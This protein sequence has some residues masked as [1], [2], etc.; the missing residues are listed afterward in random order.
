MPPDTISTA[1][2]G[3]GYPG[4]AFYYPYGA[5][6]SNLKRRLSGYPPIRDPD[7]PTQGIYGGAGKSQLSIL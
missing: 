4:D 2:N 7:I 1:T 5:E 6:L 3:K